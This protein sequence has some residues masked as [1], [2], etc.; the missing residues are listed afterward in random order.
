MDTF[1][2][3]QAAN[4]A[5]VRSA[6][7][8][9]RRRKSR[10][11]VLLLLLA[12]ILLAAARPGRSSAAE[13]SVPD[14]I[15]TEPEASSAGEA[16]TAITVDRDTLAQ[17]T[18][19]LVSNAH[20]CT[21]PTGL[22][23]VNLYEESQGDYALRSSD[24]L[25]CA[26]AL[27]PLQQL[28]RDFRAATGSE[29]LLICAG[30]RSR[31]EQ[32]DLWDNAMA[33]HGEDYTRQY[34]SQPGA[35]EHHTGLAVDFS[36]YNVAQG[37]SYDFDGAGS[38]AWML[39][40]SWKYGFVQRY[41]ADKVSITGISEEAWHFRYVGQ[42]HTAI[43]YQQNLCLEE[44]ITLLQSYPWDG[45]H[46]TETLDGVTYEL[47]YCPEDNIRVPVQGDYSL[48]GDNQGGCIVT[49]RRTDSPS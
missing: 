4:T 3:R 37:Q 5:Y 43:M 29:D 19:S 48:S 6:A 39:E 44:Y 45:E 47:W 35:S 2:T 38:S 26:T 11:S 7:L 10:I 41:P 12:G 28:C 46:L 34:F 24:I 33:L 21:F 36:L 32:Q 23:L 42:P 20:P 15:Q 1:H 14:S 13:A 40:N 22:S 18:L 30:Y 25:L 9:R 16:L 31:Q 8:R 49:V 27:E 17:G